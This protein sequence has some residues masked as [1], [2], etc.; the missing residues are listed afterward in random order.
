[1]ATDS[2][3]R[4]DYPTQSSRIVQN[5]LP[6]IILTEADLIDASF[7]AFT[8]KLASRP[9]VQEK[10]VWDV[11][12]FLTPTDTVNGAVA[13]TTQTTFV[14]DNISRFIPNMLIRNRTTSEMMH[15]TGVD[16]A[17]STLT[18][19]RAVTALGSEGGSAAVNI[20]DADNIDILSSALG[21]NSSRQVTHSTTPAEVYNYAQIFRKELALS[22]RQ[23]KREFETG[24]ELP[25][26]QIKAMKEFKMQM[27]RAL[28]FGERGRTTIDGD[29]T[30]YTEGIYNVPTTAA[31]GA[32]GTLFE[33]LWNTWL[34][35]EGMRRG[36][37]NKIAFCSSTA[38]RG[39]LE[40]VQSKATF[41]IPLDSGGV[42]WGAEVV[43][44]TSP[45]GG[46]IALIEDR[47]L[48]VHAQGSLILADMKHI[49]KRPFSNNG[50]SGD[51]QLFLGTED[52]DDIGETS[53]LYA[54]LG[55]E[56]GDEAVHGIVTGITGGAKG[57]S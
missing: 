50:R 16:T 6:K 44:Y 34:V 37:R 45:T 1:M 39:L 33:N 13:S 4:R 46:K 9:T 56:Y 10:F 11:D 17:T 49:K 20:G 57:T 54:D 35:D 29:N 7:L 31:Y 42:K 32:G 23:I 53:T 40:I 43:E 22:D 51:V 19:V 28:L 2:T 41:N 27:S 24:D 36:S 25:Y 30:T 8:N 5:V 38:L 55:L 26:Q 47:S 48:T 14:V 15:V 12:Q 52:T 3:G 21:E 18:V